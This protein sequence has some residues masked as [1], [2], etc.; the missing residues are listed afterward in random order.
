MQSMFIEQSSENTAKD[1]AAKDNAAKYNERSFSTLIRALRLSQGYFSFVLVNCN[2][3]ALRQQILDRLQVNSPVKP[4]QLLLPKSATTLYTTIPAEIDGEKPPALMLL[5]LESVEPID[6]LL[7][8]TNLL[9]SEFSKKFSFP[10]VFWVTDELL[11]KII[12]TAPDLYNRMTTIRFIS[13]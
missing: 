8:S 9:C 13:N 3:L 7:V 5:G 6:R 10:L 12:R 1:N 4:R 11:R 2:S